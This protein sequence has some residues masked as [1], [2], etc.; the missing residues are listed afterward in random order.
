MNKSLLL[1]A[2][3]AVALAACGKESPKP[4][5]TPPAAAKPAPAPA[6]P[7]PAPNFAPAEKFECDRDGSFGDL[8]KLAFTTRAARS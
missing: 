3:A 2:V 8:Q 5:P 6:A 1:A 7:T 4:K